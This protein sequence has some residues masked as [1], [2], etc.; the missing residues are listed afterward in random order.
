MRL[1]TI[2][3]NGRPVLTM[4][5]GSE[6]TMEDS[7]TTKAELLAAHRESIKLLDSM[8]LDTE[9]PR[10][11]ELREIDEALDTWLGQDLQGLGLWNGNHGELTVRVASSSE[12]DTW[13][14][15]HEKAIAEDEYEGGGDW[16][17]YL[18]PAGEADQ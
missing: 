1:Y 18:L 15:S 4:N 12:A 11:M 5:A 14:A 8:G 7:L 9:A 16:V 3:A 13:R 10:S 2:C 17:A 6:Q